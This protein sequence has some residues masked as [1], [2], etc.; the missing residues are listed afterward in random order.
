MKD[1]ISN[2]ENDKWEEMDLRG[3]SIIRLS[4]TKKI[5]ANMQRILELVYYK[6]KGG[7]NWSL[8]KQFLKLHMDGYI[9][10]HLHTLKIIAIEFDIIIVN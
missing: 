7:S 1:N 9:S 10:N 6:K 3:E 2:K 8:K 4:L 5:I